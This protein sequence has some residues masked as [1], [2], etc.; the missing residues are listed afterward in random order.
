MVINMLTQDMVQKTME[1]GKWYKPYE[2]ARLSF[3]YLP[4]VRI[5]RPKSREYSNVLRKLR[6]LAHHKIVDRR[7][8]GGYI[9]VEYRRTK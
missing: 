7:H 8:V 6:L 4:K 2:I 1:M 9:D 3:S 5:I